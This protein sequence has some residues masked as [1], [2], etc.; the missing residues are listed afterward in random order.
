MTW[1]A[2]IVEGQPSGRTR[3]SADPR[4]IA[5][6]LARWGVRFERW[7]PGAD[8]ADPR[9]AYAPDVER[10][11]AAGYDTVDA[12]RVA[13]DATDPSWSERARGMREKFRDEHTRRG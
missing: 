1:L 5:D 4:E 8:A 10:L 6:E 13:P 9:V 12:V 3:S 7:K 11:R 2:I